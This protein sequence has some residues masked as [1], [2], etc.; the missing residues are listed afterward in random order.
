MFDYSNE[1]FNTGIP[2]I[3]AIADY[4]TNVGEDQIESQDNYVLTDEDGYS[5]QLGLDGTTKDVSDS[6]AIESAANNVIDFT[7]FD[8]FSEGAY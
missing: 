1:R 7:E 4:S 3:D 6:D 2:E 8:P 5:L